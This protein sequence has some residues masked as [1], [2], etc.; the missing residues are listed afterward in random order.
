MKPSIIAASAA[1]ADEALLKKHA[2]RYAGKMSV[3]PRTPLRPQC[4]GCTGPNFDASLG[5]YRN[6]N[7]AGELV[8]AVDPR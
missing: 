6:G 8:A 3:T 4:G 7:L 1:Q 5:A 2:D